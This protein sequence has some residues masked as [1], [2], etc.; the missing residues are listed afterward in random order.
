MK[1]YTITQAMIDSKPAY[2]L[3]GVSKPGEYAYDEANNLYRFLPETLGQIVTWIQ[4]YNHT[5]GIGSLS[6]YEE[7]PIIPTVAQIQRVAKMESEARYCRCCGQSD[8]FDGAMFTT[9]P[10]SGLCD[11]CY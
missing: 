3:P 10:S 9:D 11:D 4:E 8:V 1:T 2:T 6:S 5:F 7:T